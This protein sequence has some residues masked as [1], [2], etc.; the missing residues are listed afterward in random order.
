MSIPFAGEHIFRVGVHRRDAHQDGRRV[1]RVRRVRLGHRFWP[2]PGSVLR[3]EEPQQ[4]R[5]RGLGVALLWSYQ[6]VSFNKFLQ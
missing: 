4:G 1:R 2:D 6:S 3:M 5:R